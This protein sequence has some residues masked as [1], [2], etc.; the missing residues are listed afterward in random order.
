MKQNKCP[1][2]GAPLNPTDKKNIKCDYCGSFF[3][4]EDSTT[5]NTVKNENQEQFQELRKMEIPKRP[6]I[7]WLLFSLLC[8]I[9]VFPA[10]I[11]LA[12]MKQKQYEW[13]KMYS[14]NPNITEL[15]PTKESK[16]AIYIFIIFVFICILLS[17]VV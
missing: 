1:S 17:C 5:P 13:D 14:N 11:Y 16:I 12:V 10:F 9:Y 7:S 2:C 15:K 3:V 6:T 8:F 4:I